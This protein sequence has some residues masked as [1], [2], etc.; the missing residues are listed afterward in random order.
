MS[1][2]DIIAA[3][4]GCGPNGP[5]APFA[6]P[7]STLASLYNTSLAAISGWFVAGSRSDLAN[8][9]F[10]TGAVF[11][12]QYL[13]RTLNPGGSV[14]ASGVRYDNALDGWIYGTDGYWG[15]FRFTTSA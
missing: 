1:A 13:E 7:P 3:G 4:L 5:S 12:V 11:H 2:V 15:H 10:N 14:L 9:V 6:N 8:L